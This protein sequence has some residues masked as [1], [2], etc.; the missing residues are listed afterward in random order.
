MKPYT[1]IVLLRS[2]IDGHIEARI[3]LEATDRIDASLVLARMLAHT[4]YI[5]ISWICG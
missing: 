4:A 3:D 1:A 5:F 2:G